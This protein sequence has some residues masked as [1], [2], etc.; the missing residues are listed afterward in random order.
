MLANRLGILAV[1]S[2]CI[3]PA[4][5]QVPEESTT[6]PTSAA[7]PLL[8]HRPMNFHRVRVDATVESENW[9]G[10]AVTGTGFTKATGS[11][12]VASVNCTKTPNTYAAFW[13]GID[14]Y[15]S[16]TVE[17]TGTLVIC[18]GTR[19]I[20]YAWY[21]FYPAG[22]V[23]ITSVPVSPGNEISAEVSY[24]G[25][26]F[27]T[28]IT[29]VTTG[30]SF[31]KNGRVRG[32]ARSSAE[33]I[34]EAPCC[35]SSG[36]VLPLADFGTSFFGEGHTGITDTNFATETS[37]SGAISAFGSDVQVIDMVSSSGASE[38]VPSALTSSGTS[39]QV[40]WK[41]E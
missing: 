20:Y 9:S 29:N 10:Y 37:T 16:A 11:W 26:E 39:F 15:S 4:M 24:N 22:S 27:T 30:A 32:A 34:A 35:T 23:E 12:T 18:E 36:G 19:A 41:S 6:P 3:L 28:T 21:E 25:T 17:Q 38:A 8:E 5:A 14:G 40:A 13:V 2:L 7:V 33:W 31:S 1:L